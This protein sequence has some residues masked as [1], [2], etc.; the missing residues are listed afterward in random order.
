MQKKKDTY[1]ELCR[2]KRQGLICTNIPILRCLIRV[3]S[4]EDCYLLLCLKTSCVILLLLLKY[5]GFFYCQPTRSNLKLE[6]C[7]LISFFFCT[8]LDVSCFSNVQILSD[9]VMFGMYFLV[10]LTTFD[11]PHFSEGMLKL[12]SIFH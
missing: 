9:L 7:I 5:S 1:P 2:K 4:F 3:S 11:L 6:E 8:I 12:I 10:D